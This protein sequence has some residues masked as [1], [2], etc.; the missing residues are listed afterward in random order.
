MTS[1]PDN[2][3]EPSARSMAARDGEA[4]PLHSKGQ[5]WLMSWHPPGSPPPG[6]PYGATGICVTGSGEIVLISQD[7]VGWDLPGGRPEGDEIWEETL[8]REML[9]EA[10]AT[11]VQA[12][13]LGFGRGE[14]IRGRQAGRTIVRSI[15]HADVELGPWKPRFEITHRRLIPVADVIGTLTIDDSYLRIVSRALAEAGLT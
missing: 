1:Q 15:W 4:I 11:V 12:R 5:D 10:C 13:L 6:T 7:G 3:A 2:V 14:C 8:R 9:E